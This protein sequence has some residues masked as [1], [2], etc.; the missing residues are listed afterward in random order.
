MPRNIRWDESVK[1]NALNL[2]EALLKQ[3][4]NE[5]DDLE[6]NAAVDVEWLTENKLRVTGKE[7]QK[8]RNRE[9]IVEV[10]TRKEHLVKLVEKAGKRLK[11][12]KP[13]EESNNSQQERK[14]EEVQ[15]ALDCL[16]E[17]GVREPKKAADTKGYW[18]FT[19]TLK[20]QTATREE[21]LQAVK[22]KWK[23]HPKTN[24]L[25]SSSTTPILETEQSIDWRDV[26]RTS[27]E[28]QKRL[29]TNRLMHAKQMRFDINQICVDLALVERK[30]NIRQSNHLRAVI[31]GL[32]NLLHSLNKSSDSYNFYYGILWHYAQNMTYPAFYQAWHQQEEAEKTTIPARQTLNQADLP[33]SLQSAIANDPQLSQ[34][35]HL[36]C[37]DGSQFIE[38]DRPAAEIYD[39]TLDQ[40]CP[41]C[42]SVPETMPALKLYWNSLKRNSDK[43]VV[44]V[45][46]ASS[47]DTTTNEGTTLSCPYSSAF[48]TDLSK[49]GREICVITEQPF[50]HIPLKFFAPIQ[51]IADIVQWI[52]AIV[53][54]N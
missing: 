44:L 31:T 7:K 16:K 34:I 11:L 9:Q 20:H 23:E 42:D 53:L 29:T 35:I 32:N 10:G 49:F 54:E 5:F 15:T 6:L 39:Q 48:L 52:R 33:Q 17:L 4:D 30:L 21:N 24:S 19:L 36:I 40:N 28:K 41:E 22:Q 46:Y 37:I 25:V 1:E 45:F 26:C 47:T 8:R 3:A 18:K 2:V 51:P 38:R 14:L 43:R 50:N 13:K 27:L 12:P